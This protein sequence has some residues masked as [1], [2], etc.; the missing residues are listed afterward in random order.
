MSLLTHFLRLTSWRQA[1][2]DLLIQMVYQVLCDCVALVDFQPRHSF[3]CKKFGTDIPKSTLDN[4]PHE[5]ITVCM[6]WL[7]FVTTMRFQTFCSFG[8]VFG[9]FCWKNRSTVFWLRY[10]VY[11]NHYQFCI[12]GSIQP[13]GN[14]QVCAISVGKSA[15]CDNGESSGT[16]RLQ[17]CC[18]VGCCR[19]SMR[20]RVN[21]GKRR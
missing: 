4:A 14:R 6:V 21:G 20:C 9:H 11:C 5:K 17:F 19:K 18:N 12:S 13:C 3:A 2:N 8:Q 10:T 16:G 15:I 1:V 7:C